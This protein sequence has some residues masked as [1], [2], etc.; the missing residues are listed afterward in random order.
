[1]RFKQLGALHLSIL[2]AVLAAMIGIAFTAL[3]FLDRATLN[4]VQSDRA[5]SAR[6]ANP[7]V[8]PMTVDNTTRTK[9]LNIDE[10]LKT[11]DQLPLDSPD[12]P[13][14]TGSE[15]AIPEPSNPESNLLEDAITSTQ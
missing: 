11:L 3:Y 2:I 4:R 1:M 5:L 10:A 6:D 13:E 14:P 8:R 7:Q 9:P 12:S 15:P